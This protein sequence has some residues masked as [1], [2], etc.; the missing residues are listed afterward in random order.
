MSVTDAGTL[1][2]TKMVTGQAGVGVGD[3]GD[4]G[5][6][7]GGRGVRV[8]VGVVSE[9]G[10]P[11]LQAANRAAARPRKVSRI[12]HKARRAGVVGFIGQMMDD[13]KR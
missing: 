8:G 1:S 5:I 7:V 3:G 4:V 13:E 10:T 11:L 6:G 12:K 2:G 9:E